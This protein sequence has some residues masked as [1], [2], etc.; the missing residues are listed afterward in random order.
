M[1]V[2]VA[3]L[4]TRPE[5]AGLFLSS[6]RPWWYPLYVAVRLAVAAVQGVAGIALLR[7]VG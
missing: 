2:M 5:Y 1:L 7:L 6:E 4:E 3:I